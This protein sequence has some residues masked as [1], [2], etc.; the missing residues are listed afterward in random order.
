MAI[1]S[2]VIK[3]TFPL[4]NLEYVSSLQGNP[5]QNEASFGLCLYAIFC[6]LCMFV[7]YL[8]TIF[9]GNSPR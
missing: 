7:G 5:D 8:F 3:H 2:N 9:N 4:K 6:L 1:T